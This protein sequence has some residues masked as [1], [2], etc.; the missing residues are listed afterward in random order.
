MTSHA[1]LERLSSYIDSELSD[2]RLREVEEHLEACPECRRRLAGLERVVERLGSLEPGLPPAHM[3]R[4]ISAAVARHETGTTPLGLLEQGADRLRLRPPLLPIFAL[5]IALAAI[6]FLFARGVERRQLQGT[7]FVVPAASHEPAPDAA[8]AE[9]R[10]AAGRRFDRV[11]SVWLERGLAEPPTSR[12]RYPSPEAE[13]R[14]SGVDGLDELAGLGG[15]VRFELGGEA[16]EVEFPP[17][18]APPTADGGSSG[19]G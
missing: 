19:N 14:L 9:S 18:A 1:T 5:V 6:V 2:R 12:L 7:R 13:L 16:V 3:A 4:G 15:T 11:G 10:V 8:A 17:A